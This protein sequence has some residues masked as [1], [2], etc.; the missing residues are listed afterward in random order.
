MT[1]DVSIHKW[2][3]VV[4]ETRGFKNTSRVDQKYM[5]IVYLQCT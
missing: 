2:I 1:T 4:H 3:L 5:T